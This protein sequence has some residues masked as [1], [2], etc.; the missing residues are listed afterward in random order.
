MKGLAKFGHNS[1]GTYFGLKMHLI[2]DLKRRILRV[3]FTAGNRDDREMVIP[4]SKDLIGIFMADAGYISKDLAREFYQEHKR[5]FIAKPKANMKKM[6]TK[7]QEML[8]QTRALIEVNF[9]D[10]KL[11]YGLVASLPRSVDGYLANYIYSLLAYQ[12]I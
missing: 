3:I 8:Y 6:M 7:F 11:F 1:K 10:L 9:R 2:T 12:I 4:L 5:Y